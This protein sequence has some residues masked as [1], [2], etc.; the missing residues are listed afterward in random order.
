MTLN[1]R[2]SPRLS[3]R[4]CNQ[5]VPVY[6]ESGFTLV[7]LVVVV[8]ILGILTTVAAGSWS[9]Y[10]ESKRVDVA[11]GKM[12]SM[13]Q[14]AR[15]KRLTTGFDQTISVDYRNNTMTDANGN[16][17]GFDGVDI[18]YFVCN[19]CRASDPANKTITFKENGRMGG[20]ANAKNIKLSLPN[21]AKSYIV[22]LGSNTGKVG[23]ATTCSRRKCK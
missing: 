18:Q 13:F 16:Q 14:Q 8:G 15:L 10:R 23:V 12:V 7:E 6:C 9:S 19:R 3:E 17:V 11:K 21:S 4:Q 5:Q 20:S 1:Q 2:I 22:T